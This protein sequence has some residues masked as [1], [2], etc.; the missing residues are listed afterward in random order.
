M[1]TWGIY[2]YIYENVCS[3]SFFGKERR[4]RTIGF[5]T[6]TED[7]VKSLVD[8]L[9]VKNKSYYG[10]EKPEDEFDRDYCDENYITYV[11]LKID[12]LEEIEKNFIRYR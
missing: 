9:N 7:N 10:K 6:D 11:E 8:K 3:D 12:T 4:Y 5:V 1:K 2:N